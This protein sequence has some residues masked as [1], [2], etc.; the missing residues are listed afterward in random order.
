MIPQQDA[1]EHLRVIRSLLE[2]APVYRAISAPAA[3]IGALL[4]LSTAAWQTQAAWTDGS[5]NS[6]QFMASWLTVLTITGL[7]NW[8]LLCREARQRDQPIAS[9]RV[10]AAMRA[11]LPPFLVGGVTGCGVILR[12]EHLEVAALIW[13]LCYGLALLATASFSPRSLVLLGWAF[14][15]QGLILFMLWTVDLL[16]LPGANGAASPALLMGLTFGLSHLVYAIAVGARQA[17]S[18]EPVS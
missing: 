4:A 10:R 18:E 12:G 1:I 16:S 3:L 15:A 8:L 17:H 11:L 13:T 14:V 6:K 2:K 9:E 5:L 7:L